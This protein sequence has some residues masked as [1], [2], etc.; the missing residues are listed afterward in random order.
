MPVPDRRFAACIIG[1]ITL[2]SSP[3]G[4]EALRNKWSAIFRELLGLN[5]GITIN[6]DTSTHDLKFAMMNLFYRITRDRVIANYPKVKQILLNEIEQVNRNWLVWY[7]S[8]YGLNSATVT[9]TEL[10][11]AVTDTVAVTYRDT[12]GINSTHTGSAFLHLGVIHKHS[13]L[14]RKIWSDIFDHSNVFSIHEMIEYL[15]LHGRN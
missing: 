8:C 6:A 5:I 4:T 9:A 14:G 1:F 7:C 11:R 12:T 13:R 10:A 3:A 15:V 2:I